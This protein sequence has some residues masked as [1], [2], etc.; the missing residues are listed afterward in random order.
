MATF[1]LDGREIPF[2]PGQTL[3]EAAMAA[4]IYIPHL[5]WHP[6]FEPHGSCKLCTVKVNGRLCS[7]CTFPAAEGQE[8]VSDADELRQLRRRLTQMLFVEGNH[9][10]PSCEKSGQCELQAMGY[11]VGM[12]DSHYPHFYPLREIDASHPQ[13][14]LDRD[15]CIFCELCVRA[16]R[17]EGKNVFELAGR[18]VHTRLVVNSP[19]GKLGDSDL[20]ADDLAANICPVGAI[21][22]RE[23]A[24]RIPIGQRKYDHR[25][26]AEVS[27]EEEAPLVGKHRD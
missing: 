4:G 20:E 26:I 18:G 17:A 22:I 19:T 11:Y 24:F 5:C 1:T 14:L 13:V 21:L 2:E 16:S 6:R 10:C 7:A 12:T 15:R 3:I 25:T 23:T 8:V 27:L 9:V